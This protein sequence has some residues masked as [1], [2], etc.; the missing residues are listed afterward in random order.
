[1]RLVLPTLLLLLLAFSARA[2][3]SIDQVADYI[4][5]RQLLDETNDWVYLGHFKHK[6][7]GIDNASSAILSIEENTTVR[8]YLLAKTDCYAFFDVRNQKEG[9]VFGTNDPISLETDLGDYKASTSY[10]TYKE[11][12]LMNINYGVR[13]GCPT[14]IDTEL[15]LLVFYVNKNTD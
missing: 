7:N 5:E 12:T 2:Q 3:Q 13:W 10:Y 11:A 4:K 15:R 6:L 9:Y 8:M 14:M 1:M